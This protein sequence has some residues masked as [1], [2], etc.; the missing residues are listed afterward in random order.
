M[1]ENLPAEIIQKVARN[2]SF[3]YAFRLRRASKYLLNSIEW[4]DF[5]PAFDKKY[6]PFSFDEF[7]PLSEKYCPTVIECSAKNGVIN[8]FKR[9]LN[10]NRISLGLSFRFAVI[11]GHDEIVQLIL[12]CKRKTFYNEDLDYYGIMSVRFASR[13]KIPKVMKL[14]ICQNRFQ[15]STNALNTALINAIEYGH[16]ETFELLLDRVDV[17][18][19]TLFLALHHGKSEII[20]LLLSHHSI[21]PSADENLPIRW[22]ASSGDLQIVKFLLEIDKVDPS[23]LSNEAIRKAA[24]NGHYDIVKLLLEDIRIDPTDCDNEAMRYSSRAGHLNIVKLLLNDSRVNPSALD[25]FSIRLASHNGHTEVVA[26]LLQHENVNPAARNNFAIRFASKNGFLKVV[27]LLLDDERVDPSENLN[28]AIRW[29]SNGRHF[30]VVTLLLTDS[31]VDTS[32]F[33]LNE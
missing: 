12:G 15:L 27:E 32:N 31:R 5:N 29:A 16:K 9:L 11:N 14:I 30:E 25:N 26:L 8:V 17:N 22:A 10:D 2:L 4:N 21:D 1:F 19:S 18:D 28:E 20:K 33:K 6:L 7:M 13:N 23:D 3:T 24:Q